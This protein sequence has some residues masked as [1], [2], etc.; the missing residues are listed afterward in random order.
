VTLVIVLAIGLVWAVYEITS[1]PL[2]TE[3]PFCHAEPGDPC[4]VD[5][6]HE[7]SAA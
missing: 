3:C 6:D 2:L 5:F 7:E 1:A 4:H